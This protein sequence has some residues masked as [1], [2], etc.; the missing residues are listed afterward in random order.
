MPSPAFVLLTVIAGAQA[1]PRPPVGWVAR[2]VPPDGSPEWRCANQAKDEWTVSAEQ[3][4]L[5]IAKKSSTSAQVSLPFTPELGPGE[6]PNT[7]RGLRAVEAV[8]DGY[9]AGFTRGEF[10]GGLYWFSREGDKHLKISPM[11]ASWSPEN[12]QGI[13]KD[14]RAFYVFQGL[15]H[16]G[17]DQGRVLKVQQ[18]SGRRWVPTVLVDLGSAPAAV[19][20]EAPGTWLVATSSGL[21]RVSSRGTAERVWEQKKVGQLYPSSIVRTGDGVV[22]IGMRAWV[23]RLTA[24]NPGPARAEL[25]APAS[26]PSFAASQP[27]RCQPPKDAGSP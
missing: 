8:S 16:L 10:G 17:V 21:S 14:E 26:C 15:A 3:E 5:A 27:C 24:L 4:H 25:L 19:L 13:G 23:V 9:L 12:V 18:E 11:S 7:F 6:A 2:A 20:Q 1:A 22:Y